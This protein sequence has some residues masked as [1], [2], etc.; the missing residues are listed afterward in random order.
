MLTAAEEPFQ[1]GIGVFRRGTVGWG[2]RER[3]VARHSA[4]VRAVA[5]VVVTEAFAVLCTPD[6]AAEHRRVGT[7]ECLSWQVALDSAVAVA[8]VVVEEA[9]LSLLEL[10]EAATA[11]LQGCSTLRLPWCDSSYLALSARLSPHERRCSCPSRSRR[12]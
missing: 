5:A 4:A 7:V 6:R 2:C 12:R 1:A 10:E 9:E 3:K 8:A 11:A